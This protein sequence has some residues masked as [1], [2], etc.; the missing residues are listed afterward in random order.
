MITYYIDKHTLR[1]LRRNYC[2]SIYKKSI[3]NSI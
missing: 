1:L 2:C 3:G